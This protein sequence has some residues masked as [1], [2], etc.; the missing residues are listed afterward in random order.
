MTPR[1]T[2][3]LLAVA[4]ALFQ[5]S[6]TLSVAVS[7]L[8]GLALAPERTL[9]TLP[10]AATVIT[11]ALCMIPAALL[12]QRFGRR[13]G[14]LAGT[15]IGATAAALAALA[16]YL[17]NFWLFVLA[18]ALIGAYQACAQ[19]YRFAA[20]DAVG[21]AERGR[22]ISWVVAGGVVAAFLGP[23]IARWTEPLGGTPHM[24]AY[25]ATACLSLIAS[26][27]IASLRLTTPAAEP[28]QPTGPGRAIGAIMRQGKFL[29]A[30]TVS[31]SG[32]A[33]MA[34]VMHATP[35][36]MH[37]HGHTL[38]ASATVIQWHVLG[39]FVPSFFTGMLVARFGVRPVMLAGVAAIAAHTLIA[40]TGQEYL[41][42]VSGLTL[43]GIGWNFMFIGG[44][45]LLTE[46]YTPAER[47]RTQA[48]HDFL[49]FV[50]VSVASYFAGNLLHSYG[51]YTINV[52]ALCV[53]AI[54]LAAVLWPER[55]V[56]AARAT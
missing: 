10:A 51:W 2:V 27:V 21:P 42:Y 12:M 4:Q 6:T 41:Q 26:A 22:A 56:Q 34:L 7:G 14:F 11:T 18:T 1:N 8:V 15:G 28:G 53:L 23:G 47:G 40:L 52:A 43:L 50:A 48:A 45:T 9:A 55:R 37:D 36:S 13:A 29:R 17:G 32:Y 5:T 46:T 24:A 35:I 54:P 38:A 39:M 49:M 20:A 25:L 44:T 16:I 30:V 19:Y 33:L 31:A 3:L